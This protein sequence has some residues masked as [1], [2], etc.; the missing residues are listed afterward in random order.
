MFVNL[1]NNPLPYLTYKLCCNND[2]CVHAQS[3]ANWSDVNEKPNSIMSSTISCTFRFRITRENGI[4]G[5][6][7][8]L[9]T[10]VAL[11][12][13]NRSGRINLFQQT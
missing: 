8:F 3:T 7:P 13:E 11:L 4:N 6:I 2:A 5:D 12:A 10:A 1:S 9:G